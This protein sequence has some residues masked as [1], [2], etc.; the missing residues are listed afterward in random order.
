[1]VPILIQRATGKVSMLSDS[2]VEWF[3][4]ELPNATD[5]VKLVQDP[6]PGW[7]NSAIQDGMEYV[8]LLRSEEEEKLRQ[9]NEALVL[10]Q[11]ESLRQATQLKI[12]KAKETITKLRSGGQEEDSNIVRLYRSR[13][14]NLE[15]GLDERLRA[16]DAKRSATVSFRLIAGGFLEINA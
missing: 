12:E 7:V 10:N 4:A 3:M 13:I 14:R 15:M 11:V 9:R 5:A 6:D 1:M 2:L 16:L 8:A